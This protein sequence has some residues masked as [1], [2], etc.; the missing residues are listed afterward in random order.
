[1][2]TRI[3][4]NQICRI[5]KLYYSQALKGNRSAVE[6][7]YQNMKGESLWYETRFNPVYNTANQ[8]IGVS[9]FSKDITGVKQSEKLISEQKTR[10]KEI[11]WYQSHI[12]RAPL[13]R[14]MGIIPLLQ[15]DYGDIDPADKKF[16]YQ[17]MLE[18]SRELDEMIQQIIRNTES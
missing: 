12:I 14:I 2:F 17:A 4:G 16:L 5:N 11:A 3:P 13:A 1:M 10:L 6:I 7:S 15:E 9:L 8:Q 18:S